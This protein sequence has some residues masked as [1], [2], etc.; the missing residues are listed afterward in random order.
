MIREV[1]GNAEVFADLI[2]GGCPFVLGVN[3]PEFGNIVPRPCRASLSQLR[4]VVTAE[5]QNGSQL[6]QKA[7]PESVRRGAE[8]CCSG[9]RSADDYRI[10]PLGA[11]R[12]SFRHQQIDRAIETAVTESMRVNL[13]RI[14][15]LAAGRNFVG[16]VIEA[17]PTF[18]ATVVVAGP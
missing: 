4:V 3:C 10:G 1:L 15:H 16:A 11:G 9:G 5:I 6:S 13:S 8:K 12:G 2:L 17:H 7:I 14:N 18:G